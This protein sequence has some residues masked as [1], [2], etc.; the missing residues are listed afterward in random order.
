MLLQHDDST[1]NIFLILLL[2]LL[3][4][5]VRSAKRRPQSPEWTILSHVNCFDHSGRAVVFRFF[6]GIVFI[7]VVPDYQGVLVVSS[8]SP[9]VKL[10]RFPWHLFCPACAQCGRTGRNT[11][12]GQCRKVQLLGCPSHIIN[13]HI[14][15]FANTIDREHQS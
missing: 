5:G 14:T 2:L 12:L 15:A 1:I 9:W 13:P 7:C 11:M 4:L 3:L 8:S 10:L 6:C